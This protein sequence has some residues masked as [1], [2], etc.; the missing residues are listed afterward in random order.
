[1]SIGTEDTTRTQSA[2]RLTKETVDSVIE[3]LKELIHEG[4]VRRLIVKDAK[5]ATVLVVPLTVGVVA[6]A[7][8][9]I[10]AAL[11]AIAALAAE[12]TIEVEKVE[13]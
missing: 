10:W 13:A 1:M 9:P 12:F 2:F 6:T 8:L 5:G 4:N 7:L 11:A 3:K